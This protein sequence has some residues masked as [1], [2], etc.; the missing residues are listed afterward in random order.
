MFGLLKKTMVIDKK[1]QKALALLHF[2]YEPLPNAANSSD[3]L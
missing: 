3:V 1:Y 2:T